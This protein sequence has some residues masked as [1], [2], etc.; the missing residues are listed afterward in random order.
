MGRA[1]AG[2][3][4]VWEDSIGGAFLPRPRM[5][6]LHWKTDSFS[7]FDL[8]FP[9]KK[10][11]IFVLMRS[12]SVLSVN[13]KTG[14]AGAMEKLSP[15]LKRGVKHSARFIGRRFRNTVHLALQGWNS[16]STSR[17][18]GFSFSWG[19]FHLLRPCRTG[20]GQLGLLERA[21]VRKRELHFWHDLSPQ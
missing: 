10:T 8:I 9:L 5:A 6:E 20:W 21:L 18:L 4:G 3:S 11:V 17:R 2:Y 13:H 19:T 15:P 7:P 12:L 14:A 1:S 16:V